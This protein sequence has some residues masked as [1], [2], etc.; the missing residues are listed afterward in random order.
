MKYLI[1]LCGILFL[2][3]SC[4][5]VLI[6]HVNKAGDVYCSYDATGGTGGAFK[7]CVWCPLGTGQCGTLTE[8]YVLREHNWFTPNRYD[9]YT[10][11]STGT[12]CA[13][14]Q[15]NEYFQKK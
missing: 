3:T 2:M 12:T 13:E 9:H 5:D 15:G 10:L 11:T 8:V 1:V 7:V 6:T 14:C 4:D